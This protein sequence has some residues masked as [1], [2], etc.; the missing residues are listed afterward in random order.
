MKDLRKHSPCQN[1]GITVCKGA[2]VKCWGCLPGW[3]QQ[4]LWVMN[5]VL[6]NGNTYGILDIVAWLPQE[7]FG[8]L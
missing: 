7:D 4:G 5:V 1:R 6:G 8:V 2:A 3:A